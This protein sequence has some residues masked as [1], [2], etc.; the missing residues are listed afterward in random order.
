MFECRT[1][2]EGIRIVAPGGKSITSPRSHKM[3]W[4]P[5]HGSNGPSAVMEHHPNERLPG[6]VWEKVMVNGPK[7]KVVAGQ[8]P[9]GKLRR[10]EGLESKSFPS[11]MV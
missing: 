11:S 3:R 9:L 1:T 2:A 10:R 8:G 7:L 6:S 4:P 5:R